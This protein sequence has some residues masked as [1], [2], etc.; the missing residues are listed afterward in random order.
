MPASVPAA[1]LPRPP[2]GAAGSG[3][4]FPGVAPAA[5]VGGGAPRPATMS[6]T[7]VAV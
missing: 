5:G 2:F 4:R 3:N 1:P 6:E 7:S